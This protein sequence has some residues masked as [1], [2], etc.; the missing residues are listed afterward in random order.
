MQSL[1]LHPRPAE[2]EAKAV[3]TEN[4]FQHNPQ[5]VL[6][7]VSISEPWTRSLYLTHIIWK[8]LILQARNQDG[9]SCVSPK[10]V[11]QSLSPQCDYLEVWP[12]RKQL[13]LNEVVRVEPQSDRTVALYE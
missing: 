11:R 2:P 7:Y 12:S 1:G 4:L 8:I 3:P 10:F 9:L 13:K 6:I 5:V